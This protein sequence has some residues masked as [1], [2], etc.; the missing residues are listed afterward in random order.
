[1][2]EEVRTQVPGNIW[3]VQVKPGDTVAAGDLLFIMEVMKTEVEHRSETAGTVSAVAI[4]EGQEGVEADL[5][6]VVIS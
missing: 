5:V 6:A 2:A 3:K 1:M 4:E